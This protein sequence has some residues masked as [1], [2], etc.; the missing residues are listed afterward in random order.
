MKL[1]QKNILLVFFFLPTVYSFSQNGFTTNNNELEELYER[2]SIIYAQK[3]LFT[4][5]R[6]YNRADLAAIVYNEYE[7]DSNFKDN[8]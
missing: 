2:Y 6:P 8:N 1:N 4:N 3:D 5:L 7:K